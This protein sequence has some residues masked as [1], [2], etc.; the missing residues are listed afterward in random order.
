MGGFSFLRFSFL[1][2]VGLVWSGLFCFALKLK[3]CFFLFG[4]GLLCFSL[5]FLELRDDG[6]WGS[7][8]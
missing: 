4:R 3:E 2:V 8:A 6:V 5:G 1:V 7:S